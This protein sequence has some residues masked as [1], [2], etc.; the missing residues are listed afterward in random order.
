MTEIGMIETKPREGLGKT[1]F[2]NATFITFGAIA[3]KGLSFLF[4]IF[5]I[6]RLGGDRFGQ[7]SIVLGFVG[8]F[9]IFAE[10]GM[11][12]YVMREIARDRS[13]KERLFWNLV[14]VRFLLAILG[15]VGITAA[16]SA[17]GY[18]TEILLGIFIFT[19]TFLL[20]AFLQPILEVLTA[21]ERLDYVTVVNFIGRF[22]FMLFG[23]VLLYMGGSYLWL[24]VA[25]LVQIPIQI[26]LALWAAQRHGIRLLPIRLD[27]NSWPS[28]I[29]SG[30][31]FGLISLFLGIA[32]S[33]DTVMLSWYEPDYVVGWYNVAYGLVP[34][35]LIFFRGFKT[36][37]VPSLTRTYAVDPGQVNPWYHRSVKFI[38]MTSLPIAVGGMLVAFPMIRFLY[39]DEFIPSGLALQILIWDVPFLMFA[40][41]CGNMTTIVSEEKAAARIYGINTIAN[42]ILNLYAIPRFGLVGAAMVTVITDLIGAL[43]FHF[44]LSRKLSLPNMVPTLVRVIIAALVMAIAIWPA[45]GLH[46]FAQ[47]TLGVFVYTVGVLTLRL[48]DDEEREIIRRTL[49]KVISLIQPRRLPEAQSPEKET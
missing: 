13:A 21:Y 42:V 45:R 24:V 14:A 28:L 5:V 30:I 41:F 11:S 8:L 36:A 31:P 49:R 3:L 26:A 35:L 6:R 44:L 33:I 43:Q 40:S 25:G 39:T 1:I 22:V 29:R 32:F 10:L 19:T 37:I 47:V 4:N 23:G 48:I 27:L 17:F 34:S 15:M 2:R 18:S 7:Y 38:M 9:S 20:A 12:Q 46:L 16:G